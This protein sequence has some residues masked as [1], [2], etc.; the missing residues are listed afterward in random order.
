MKSRN[1]QEILRLNETNASQTEEMKNSYEKQL[2]SV[3]AGMEQT[4]ESRSQQA[5]ELGDL[6]RKVVAVVV[7]SAGTSTT[8]SG[9]HGFFKF[10]FLCFVLLAFIWS[11]LPLNVLFL[12]FFLRTLCWW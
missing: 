12:F 2:E 8:V 1:E 3:M 9:F 5:I 11:P 7:R 6:N 10:V 4:E